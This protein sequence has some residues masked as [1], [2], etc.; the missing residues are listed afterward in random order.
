VGN[1]EVSVS[2]TAPNDNGSP[3][4]GYT[5]EYN[6]GS[7]ACNTTTCTISGLNNGSTYTFTVTATN[8]VG[9][10]PA[11]PA[12]AEATPDVRPEAPGAPTVKFGDGELKVD[13]NVPQNEGTPITSY[14]VRISPSPCTS[15]KSVSGT[16][17]TWSGLTNGTNYTF[18]VRAINDAPEPGK[19]SQWSAPEHPSGP[20]AQPAAPKVTRIDD[21]AGGRLMVE[22]SAP[23]ANGDPISGYQLAMFKDGN[24]VQTFTPGGGTTSREVQ[25]QNAHD[26]SFTL[27]ATNRSGDSKVSARSAQ[28]RSFG[29]P[30][31]VGDVSVKPTGTDN[32]ATVSHNTP[33]N[34]GQ[35]ISKYEYRINGGS[36]HSLPSGKEITVPND[37]TNYRIQV[38]ACN[39]YCGA[40]SKSSNSF[41]TYG[42]PGSSSIDIKSSV[43]DKKVSFSWTN[44]GSDNG[45]KIT[46]GRY[47]ID[48][49]GW[50]NFSGTSGSTSVTGGWSEKHT[51]DVQI[52]NNHNQR[53]GTKSASATAEKKPPP[54]NPPGVTMRSIGDANGRP[55]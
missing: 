15:Q 28:V 42:P 34:N 55:G 35:K 52:Q 40:W 19:W 9:E 22:W 21:A 20:P 33:S 5:V 13:W 49:G 53:S 39:T 11:S 10:S 44:A 41:S 4:S 17:M 51:I 48:G 36:V 38:R 31:R 45:A 43:N 32:T 26:Y 12:S 14:D 2:G 23:N 3:I 54:K 1:H 18:Q 30:G 47:R 8:A 25:V 27:V 24:K 29:E 46:G 50:K 16:S 7:Q 37:G 6:G